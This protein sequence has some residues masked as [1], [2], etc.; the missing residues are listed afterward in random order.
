MFNHWGNKWQDART[1]MWISIESQYSWCTNLSLRIRQWTIIN[2]DSFACVGRWKTSCGTCKIHDSLTIMINIAHLPIYLNGDR[3]SMVEFKTTKKKCWLF[4]FEAEARIS[5]IV[6]TVQIIV[7]SSQ[8][9]CTLC[10]HMQTSQMTQSSMH[11]SLFCFFACLTERTLY[12]LRSTALLAV[13]FLFNLRNCFKPC[14]AFDAKQIETVNVICFFPPFLDDYCL[15]IFLLLFSDGSTFGCSLSRKIEKKNTQT[16]QSMINIWS[17]DDNMERLAT[18]STI[19]WVSIRLLQW[20]RNIH[21][22]DLVLALVFL[23]L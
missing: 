3:A 16:Q 6:V 18:K 13:L 5:L 12:F 19:R 4:R 1:H 7:Y 15:S 14:F 22:V 23:N 11:S 9:Y 8:L 21:L 20:K 2:N 17:L 10:A